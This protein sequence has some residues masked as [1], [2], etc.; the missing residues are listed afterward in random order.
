MNEDGMWKACLDSPLD[1]TPRLVLADL[2]AEHGFNA[3]AHDMR[4]LPGRLMVRLAAP[5]ESNNLMLRLLVMS[6]RERI[7]E[8]N[9]W[10]PTHNTLHPIIDSERVNGLIAETNA[11][12]WSV[13]E[14]EVT[15]VHLD[16]EGTHARL[17]FYASGEQGEDMVF[18]GDRIQGEA[19]AI[20]DPEGEVGFEVLNAVIVREMDTEY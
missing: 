5:A 2:L 9:D 13:D 3:L 18:H 14:I 1:D 12:S 6:E 4:N 20:I 19:I 15:D 10:L 11:M 8:V 17:R 7:A 16:G